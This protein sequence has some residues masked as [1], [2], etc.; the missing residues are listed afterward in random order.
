M[1]HPF[2]NNNSDDLNDFLRVLFNNKNTIRMAHEKVCELIKNNRMPG[3]PVERQGVPPPAGSNPHAPVSAQPSVDSCPLSFQTVESNISRTIE[4]FRWRSKTDKTVENY[5][6]Q[7]N[8]LI[9]ILKIKDA[10]KNMSLELLG[11]FQNS[12]T[13]DLDEISEIMFHRRTSKRCFIKA[14]SFKFQLKTVKFIIGPDRIRIEI[15]NSAHESADSNRVFNYVRASSEDT[16]ARYG[17]HEFFLFQK[18]EDVAVKEFKFLI[19]RLSNEHVLEELA[20][21][22]EPFLTERAFLDTKVLNVIGKWLRKRKIKIQANIFTYRFTR[23][24]PT[25]KYKSPF[26]PIFKSL[27]PETLERLNFQMWNDDRVLGMKVKFID[28]S[29]KLRRTKQWKSASHLNISDNLFVKQW[30]KFSH[31]QSIYLL[32][33]NAEDVEELKKTFTNE[34]YLPTQGCDIYLEQDYPLNFTKIFHILSPN[35]K[36]TNPVNPSMLVFPIDDQK[37]VTME[38]EHNM[39]QVRVEN[40]IKNGQ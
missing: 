27:K 29:D 28:F 13:A 15:W 18:Y 14:S 31:F 7:K 22:I 26:F 30:K 36:F 38:F 24:L 25:R 4:H 21:E 11:T 19:K 39:I 23:Q 5:R 16:F 3:D 32:S 12:T 17:D 6:N 10:F 40:R 8:D 33:V 35:D 2:L 20:F 1:E 9:K 34:K 37:E